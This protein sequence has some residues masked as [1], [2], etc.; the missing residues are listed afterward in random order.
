MLLSPC[1]Y[2]RGC[3]P[4]CNQPYTIKCALWSYK[5]GFP[6]LNTG[7]L[8]DPHTIASMAGG[9]DLYLSPESRT[10][11]LVS[12]PFQ[13]AS[14]KYLGSFE[15]GDFAHPTRG[16]ASQVLM[17]SCLLWRQYMLSSPNSTHLLAPRSFHK[18]PQFRMLNQGWL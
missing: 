13:H 1:V 7:M 4:M 14:R 17:Q 16:Q 15:N 10:P 9:H 8:P 12:S 5:M 6:S 3:A 11:G 18:S 2:F